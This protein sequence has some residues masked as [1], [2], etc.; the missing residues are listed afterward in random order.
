MFDTAVSAITSRVTGGLKAHQVG[1]GDVFVGLALS[2]DDI[3]D[4][5]PGLH[6]LDCLH[7]HLAF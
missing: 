7:A 3:Q 1:N 6:I 5:S 4:A 2:A